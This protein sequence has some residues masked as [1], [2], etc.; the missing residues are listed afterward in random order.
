MVAS[1]RPLAIMHVT[2]VDGRGGPP[3]ADAT[4]LVRD[5]RIEAAGPTAQVP[6]AADVTTLD[7]RGRWLIPGEGAGR[8]MCSTWS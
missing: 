8:R 6:V 1:L 4:V 5:G 2:L 3:L 7:G